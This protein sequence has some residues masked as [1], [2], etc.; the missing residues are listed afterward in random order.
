VPTCAVVHE[1]GPKTYS[2]DESEYDTLVEEMK[3]YAADRVMRIKPVDYGITFTASYF[4][5]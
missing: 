3:Y 1:L 4:N 5:D 2:Y